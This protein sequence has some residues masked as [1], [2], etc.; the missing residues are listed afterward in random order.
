MGKKEILD[1]IAPEPL[2]FE[3]RLIARP[4]NVKSTGKD[5]RNPIDFGNH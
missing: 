1:E 3:G 5:K 2:V 4:E